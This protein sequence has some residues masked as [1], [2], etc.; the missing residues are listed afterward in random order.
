MEKKQPN[1]NSKTYHDFRMANSKINYFGLEILFV[2]RRRDKWLQDNIDEAIIIF[3]LITDIFTKI[4]LDYKQHMLI[5][6]EI[7]KSIIMW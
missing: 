6:I 4:F 1:L 7:E 3:V 5:R 2:D